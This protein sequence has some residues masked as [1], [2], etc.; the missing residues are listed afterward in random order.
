[1]EL[2]VATIVNLLIL[3]SMYILTALG[4]AF[5]FNMLRILNLAHGAIYMIGGYIGYIFILALGFNHWLSL[6][7]ATLIVGA[8][9]VFLEK[10]CFRPF[11]GDFNRTVMIC[12]AIV[13]ILQTTVTIMV[14]NKTM[15]IPPFAEGVLKVGLAFI[16]YERIVTFSI[17]AILLGAIIW[18]V[19]RT[20]LGQQMQA[21]AQ[22]RL[23]ASL[24]GIDI[25]RVSA[26]AFALGC[27]LA[28]LAG[29]LMG[30]YLRLS[31]YMGDLMLVRVLIIVMLAGAGSLG[32][33]LIAGLILGALNAALPVLI[34]GAGS[35]AIIIAVV[36]ILL[37]IRPQGFFGYEVEI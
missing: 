23:G 12:V 11:V 4:F 25:Y 34:S 30:A 3:S 6:L 17:G 32:G 16:S 35:D 33:I 21:I 24:Q 14:G 29:V 36:V 37:L 7:L 5:L 8:F 19:N 15:A 31:P 9:G 2:A 26:L 18:F 10:F 22:H 13:V 20:K 28:A 27:G 1:M